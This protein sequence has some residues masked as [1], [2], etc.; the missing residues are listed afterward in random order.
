MSN[1]YNIEMKYAMDYNILLYEYHYE[2]KNSTRW[3][4]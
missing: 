3:L 1:K 4:V 2:T